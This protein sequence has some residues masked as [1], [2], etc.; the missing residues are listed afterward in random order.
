MLKNI[1][2][3]LLIAFPLYA[4]DEKPNC[5]LVVHT[6]LK[7]GKK[8]VVVD[9]IHTASRGL[10]QSEA[11]LRRLVSDYDAEEIENIKT[12]FSFREATLQ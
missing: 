12:S 7:T 4:A 10:C 11:Q 5:K 3:A 9:E 8:K 1:L 6:F 2:L